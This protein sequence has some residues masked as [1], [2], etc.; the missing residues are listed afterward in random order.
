VEELITC[1]LLNVH[2]VGGVRVTEMHT[3]EPFVLEPI[4]ASVDCYVT[5]LR[6]S[7]LLYP[8]NTGEKNGN[9]MIQ[10]LRYLFI[11]RKS[12]IQLGGKYYTIFLLN[13]Q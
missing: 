11:S 12:L 10:Y 2:G 7:D 3:A 9:I 6:R 5:D 13:L 1:Q 4:I 8:S